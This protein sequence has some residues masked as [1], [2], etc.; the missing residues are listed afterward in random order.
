MPTKKAGR[1]FMHFSGVLVAEMAITD[2]YLRWCREQT[3]IC[4]AVTSFLALYIWLLGDWLA[5]S[6]SRQL[7]LRTWKSGNCDPLPAVLRWHA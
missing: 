3:S 7:I 5:C 2:A 6:R 1:L 4:F